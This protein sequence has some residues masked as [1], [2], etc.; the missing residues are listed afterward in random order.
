MLSIFG[1]FSGLEIFVITFNYMNLHFQ[2][3]LKINCS[4]LTLYDN[5][6]ICLELIES[7]IKPL[8]KSYFVIKL[9]LI[10]GVI[11][12]IVILSLISL[13]LCQHASKPS[14]RAPFVPAFIW[15]YN[16]C[17]WLYCLRVAIVCTT[18]LRIVNNCSIR[19]S[20]RVSDYYTHC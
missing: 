3:K 19:S 10:R 20:P 14:R 9:L 1:F 12:L 5:F 16:N 6:N 18:S 8:L 4:W 15:K 2:C 17:G 13:L 7:T 11:P